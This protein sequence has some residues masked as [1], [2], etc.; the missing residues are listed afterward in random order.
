MPPNPSSPTHFLPEI[1]V[2]KFF[3]EAPSLALGRYGGLLIEFVLTDGAEEENLRQLTPEQRTI[4]YFD[5]IWGQVDNGGFVQ[6]FGNGYGKYLS[7]AIEGLRALGEPD[8]ADLFL[9]AEKEYRKNWWQ[10][11]KAKLRGWRGWFNPAFYAGQGGLDALDEE[12]YRTKSGTIARLV[13][14]V[15]STG[16]RYFTAQ[17]G[18]TYREDTSGTLEGFYRAGELQSRGTF[19]QGQLHGTYEEYFSGGALKAS[20]QYERGGLVETKIQNE[21]GKLTK[22]RSQT[23]EPGVWREVS[24]REDGSCYYGLCD[25]DG[26]KVA[27]PTGGQYP[28]GQV[29]REG[30]QDERGYSVGEVKEYYPDGKPKLI[31]EYIGRF[32]LGV[33]QFWLP[34]GEQTLKDGNGYRLVELKLREGVEVLREE[35]QDGVKHGEV[36]RSREGVPT[37]VE[38]YH[39]GK[40]HGPRKQFYPNGS[41]KQIA[42]Y[43]QGQLVSKQDFPED[44][45]GA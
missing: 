31:G 18:Q 1:N 37:L 29:S 39:A 6:L 33:Q 45:E 9:R 3:A 43:E 10:F 34:G 26:N 40:L 27:G 20:A 22:T 13:A 11:L 4:F 12:F 15:R 38:N 35:Y 24:Y 36:K 16:S 32:T 28:N 14:L 21:Q 8:M 23:G 42:H 7:P 17:N 2:P 44:S 19:H 30:Y 41:P 25:Q 5:I